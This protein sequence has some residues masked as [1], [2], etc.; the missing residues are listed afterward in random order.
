VYKSNVFSPPL[1]RI[2]AKVLGVELQ[3]LFFSGSYFF[4]SFVLQ[5]DVC[6][7]RQAKRGEGGT[8]FKWGGRAPL[9]SPL[10]TAL[11][12]NRYGL[13]CAV[14]INPPE[15]PINDEAQNETH[16]ASTGVRRY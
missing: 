15:L 9:V 12:H 10:A 5:L 7:N 2:F 6:S 11:G 8:D 4:S 16:I 1:L 14:M 13:V 3:V